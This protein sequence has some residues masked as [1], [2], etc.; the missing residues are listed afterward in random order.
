MSAAD[1]EPPGWP[2]WALCVIRMMCFRRV[3]AF[4]LRPSMSSSETST[5]DW[6]APALGLRPRGDDG[7]FLRAL[8]GAHRAFSGCPDS[9]P[10]D[11][12]CGPQRDLNRVRRVIISSNHVRLAH[13]VFYIRLI[14]PL[15]SS[16]V[17]G[18]ATGGTGCE[19]DLSA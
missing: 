18:S 7:R 17:R 9:I 19:S 14:I 15:Y 6:S 8:S 16:R 4:F 10:H 2:L 5:M 1:M 12:S 13:A 11:G 3:T